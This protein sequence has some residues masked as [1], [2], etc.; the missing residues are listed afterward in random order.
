MDVAS[1]A[2]V[3]N[4]HVESKGVNISYKV[5]RKFNVLIAV[6]IC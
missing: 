1:N 2:P 6:F 3:D 4:C 5:D